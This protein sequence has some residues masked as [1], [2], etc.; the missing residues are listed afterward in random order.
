MRQGQPIC[1]QAQKARG[2]DVDFA[3]WSESLFH[4]PGMRGP[5]R[6]EPDA[7]REPRALGDRNR[8]LGTV[9]GAVSAPGFFRGTQFSRAW[10]RNEQSPSESS[11]YPMQRGAGGGDEAKRRTKPIC[12]QPRK[13]RGINLEFARRRGA[14]APGIFRATQFPGVIFHDQSSSVPF[15]CGLFRPRLA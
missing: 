5:R 13:F 1:A 7:R 6:A 11:S 10:G 12:A 14:P 4:V 2:F 9:P 15:Y 8:R 3:Q